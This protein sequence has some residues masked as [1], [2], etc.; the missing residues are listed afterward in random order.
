[1]TAYQAINKAIIVILTTLSIITTRF[2]SFLK[3]NRVRAEFAIIMHH[4]NNM[5]AHKTCQIS[6]KDLITTLPMR[7]KNRQMVES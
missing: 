1:M 4:F 6:L 5:A 3:L 7:R 2:G